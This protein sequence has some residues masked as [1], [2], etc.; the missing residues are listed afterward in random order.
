VSRLSIIVPLCGGAESFEDTLVSILQNR[1]PHSE[2]AVVTAGE[3]DDPYD[4]AQELSFVTAPAG[5]GM[6][7]Q[8]NLGV[9]A[10][11]GEV[12]HVVQCGLSVE[13]GWTD[14]ALEHFETLAVAAVAPVV[15]CGSGASLMGIRAGFNGRRI[16][17]QAKNGSAMRCQGPTL[18][19]GFWRR[20]AWERVGGLDASLGPR[21][22]ALDLALALDALGRQCIIEPLSRIVETCAR[23]DSLSAWSEGRSAERLFWK[24][25]SHAPGAFALHTLGLAGEFL[26]ALPRPRRMIEFLGRLSVLT[27][28]GGNS[29]PAPNASPS[30]SSGAEPMRRRDGA[31]LV[32]D[33]ER[34][35]SSHRAIQP[36]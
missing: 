7:D 17:V 13:D 28:A 33:R 25:A 12:I 20:S 22:A 4:L 26:A 27:S 2:V 31:N 30:L 23:K 29:N 36:Y 24:R 9:Q 15:L 19:A 10:T 18:Q 3:Y 5:A 14:P 16:E 21:Y 1:P 8:I 11:R 35:T 34:R 6:V 32:G